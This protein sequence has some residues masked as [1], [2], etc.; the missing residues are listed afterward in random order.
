M[1][2]IAG[3]LA[4]L[5]WFALVLQFRLVLGVNAEAGLGIGETLV[6][7]FSYFTILTNILAASVLTATML[8]HTRSFL[9]RPKVQAAVAAYITIVGAVYFLILR[10]LWQPQG[11]Q[12]LA[13]TLLHY[14]MPVLYVLFWVVFAQKRGIGWRDSV[15]WLIFPLLY[16]CAV[17]A[18]GVPSKFYP[19]PFIDANTLTYPEIARNAGGMLVAFLVVGLLVVALSRW[20]ARG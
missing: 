14:V 1:R 8:G 4:A 11:P 9:T 5:G 19:Y 13:D 2:L 16:L 3:V 7:F 20:L 10:H 6:R 18:R 15:N 12:W 17:L